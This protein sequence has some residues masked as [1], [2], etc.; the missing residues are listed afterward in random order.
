MKDRSNSIGNKMI[1]IP[2]SFK[3]TMSSKEVGQIMKEEAR[4]LWPDGEIISVQVADGGEGSVDAFLSALD[5]ER[6][7]ETVSGPY[8]EKV[9]ACYAIVGKT[10][11]IEMASVAGLPLVGKHL[12]AGQTTTY[13]VGELIR[14]ALD[15]KVEK[16]ILALGGSATNDGGTGMASALGVRFYNQKKEQFVPVGDTLSQISKIDIEEVDSRLKGVQVVAMC[17][18]QNTLCGELG[19]AKVFA[20][21]KGATEEQVI[22]LDEG[23]HHF[24]DQVKRW[25]HKEILSLKGGA[26]AGGMGAGAVAFLDAQLQSGIDVV[27]DT[28]GFDELLNGCKLVIT[29]EGKID[30]QSINGKVISGVA[31][32]ASKKQVP[33]L[34]VAGAVDDDAEKAYEIGVTAIFSITQKP[35]SF[36][37]I[38]KTTTSD[39]RRTM[40]SVFRFAKAFERK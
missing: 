6:V 35:M 29:G 14:K 18:I 38:C 34:V 5:G 21:Q 7:Y 32:R 4:K 15:R 3:G 26:A 13:G 1:M 27:L 2:D 20:P 17:D 9:Q 39:L 37:E 22:R 31:R 10:A 30:E 12:S 28:I 8:G 33:V 11:I 40:R 24:S 36:E 25:L 19:A 23:L 16:I